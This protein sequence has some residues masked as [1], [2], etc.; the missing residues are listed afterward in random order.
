[1]RSS[2]THNMASEPHGNPYREQ[3]E[4]KVKDTFEKLKKHR[5]QTAKEVEKCEIKLKRLKE[6]FLKS[7]T[8]QLTRKQRAVLETH[9]RALARAQRAHRTADNMYKACD[10]QIEKAA[11]TLAA[12][13][14]AK[15]RAKLGTELARVNMTV[16]ID[17][18]DEE[19]AGVTEAEDAAQEFTDAFDVHVNK[20][21]D[22][23]ESEFYE[24]MEDFVKEVTHEVNSKHLQGVPG[25]P[26]SNR[27]AAESVSGTGA[28]AVTGSRSSDEDEEEFSARKASAVRV[29]AQ[30][31]LLRVRKTS[32]GQVESVLDMTGQGAR[33]DDLDTDNAEASGSDGGEDDGSVSVKA[34]EDSDEADRNTRMPKPT[35]RG[36][37]RVK[38]NKNTSQLAIYGQL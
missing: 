15:T 31:R 23:D 36:M 4:K 9:M 11:G 7:D 30:G 38:R 26:R 2:G 22:E 1:M 17:R 32:D 25:A 24:M 12:Q 14:A 18:M 13:E 16:D 28:V 35:K 19:Q 8:I 34:T 10:L 27:R 3:A 37:F 20:Y 33:I 6:E 29:P 21:A 5:T